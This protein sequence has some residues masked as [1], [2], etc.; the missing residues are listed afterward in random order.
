[1]TAR[2]AGLCLLAVMALW[3]ALP[4][5][6]VMPDEI[7][8]DPALEARA[9][10][11]SQN[12]RCLVCQNESIDSSNADL[13]RDLRLLVR[14]RLLAGDSDRQVQDYL[15]ARYGDFVLLTPPMR[16]ATYLLWFGPFALLLAGAGAL[17]LLVRRQRRS[18]SAEAGPAPLSTAERARL[19]RL[20]DAAEEGG[21]PPASPSSPGPSKGA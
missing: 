21:K 15:V 17:L 1:M 19:D 18:G 7:L 8:D 14:E 6:A 10:A 16:P 20:L 3:T 5:G 11:L 12:I 13:A 9:R 4:A 2:L